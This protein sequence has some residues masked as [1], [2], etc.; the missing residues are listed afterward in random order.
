MFSFCDWGNAI[1]AMKRRIGRVEC[2]LTNPHSF[3]VRPVLVPDLGRRLRSVPPASFVRQGDQVP[4]NRGPEE[5][6]A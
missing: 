6:C 5:G 3:T 2:L 1:V 4:R